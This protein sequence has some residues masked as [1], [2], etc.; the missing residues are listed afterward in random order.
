MKTKT[1]YQFNQECDMIEKYIERVRFMAPIIS[2]AKIV[3]DRWE[4]RY[5]TTLHFV[6]DTEAYQINAK[7]AASTIEGLNEFVVL[8]Q[9]AMKL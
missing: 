3:Y 7:D 9:K 4:N 2:D 8:Y 1:K 6:N 5:I